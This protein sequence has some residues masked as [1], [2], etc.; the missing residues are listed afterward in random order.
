MLLNTNLSPSF[1]IQYIAVVFYFLSTRIFKLFCPLLLTAL[2]IQCC[3]VLSML[4]KQCTNELRISTHSSNKQN[5]FRSFLRYYGF[6]HELFLFTEAALS[7]Q[8]FWLLS[9][10]FTIIFILISTFFN[11]YGFSVSILDVEHSIFSVIQGISFFAVIF[12]ASQVESEDRKLRY[13]VKDFAFR[14]KLLTETKEC[15][16]TLLDFVNSR[17]RLV[18]TASG[19]IQFTKSLLLT[20]AGFLVTYNLLVL[21][22]NPPQ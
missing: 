17:C 3:L 14:L 22:L 18:L 11:F 1:T 21:Q 4:I 13:E 5:A 10:H 19:V 9:S 12:Y 7:L 20:S 15:S 6:C 16:E 8:I 2:Y